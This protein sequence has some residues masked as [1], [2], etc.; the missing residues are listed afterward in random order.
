[1]DRRDYLSAGILGTSSVLGATWIYQRSRADSHESSRSS[2]KP[3]PDK[4]SMIN[5]NELTTETDFR[6]ARYDVGDPVEGFDE[7]ESWTTTAGRVTADSDQTYRS[8]QSLHLVAETEMDSAGAR[9]EFN[10]P[11]DFTNRSFSLAVKWEHFGTPYAEVRLSIYDDSGDYIQFNQVLEWNDLQD[12]HRLDLG[13]RQVEGEP[14]LESITSIKV[15]TWVGDSR[16]SVWV[17]DAR[18]TATDAEGKVL[19]IFDDSRASQYSVAYPLLD[20]F[21]FSGCVGLIIR[22]LGKSD[23]LTLEEL[24]ELSDEGWD[25]CSHPQFHEQPLTEFNTDRLDETLAEY[26]QWL[27]SHGFERGADCIIYPFGKIDDESLNVVAKYHKLGL[28]VA[29]QTP[30][31]PAISSPLL[32]GR[33]IGEHVGDVKRAVTLAGEYGMAVPIMYHAIGGQQYISE[34]KFEHTLKHIDD[35]DNVDVVTTSEWLARLEDKT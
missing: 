5:T 32:A 30:Y 13:V 19:L 12:W 14:D 28:K 15:R 34:R 17:E 18:T 20:K 7:F 24:Q 23:Y 11:K 6:E 22:S 4:T 33:V 2:E 16:A 3:D 29:G 35:T 10:D 1:M 21:G 31:G 9:Y 25:V 8:G 27:L 26:K